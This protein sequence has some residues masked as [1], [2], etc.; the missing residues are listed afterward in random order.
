MREQVLDAVE[1][2]RVYA[3]SHTIRNRA[4]LF[5]KALN[6][7]W[8]APRSSKP[9]PKQ[10]RPNAHTPESADDDSTEATAMRKREIA[11]LKRALLT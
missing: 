3:T 5:I 8:P 7:G 2:A 4:A 9:A 1:A 6:E 10:R 11:K